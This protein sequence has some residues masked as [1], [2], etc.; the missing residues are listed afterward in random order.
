MR[1]SGATSRFR[2]ATAAVVWVALVAA[3]APS[4]AASPG[5][6]A[7]A[8]TPSAA[9]LLDSAQSDVERYCTAIADAA[10]DAHFAWQAKR[11][12]ELQTEIEERI[13]ALEAKRAEYEEW[14]QR[15]EESLAKAE[16]SVVA[17]YARM[18]PDAAAVQLARM[19]EE[20]A[21]AV[22][23]KLNSRLASAILNEMD[24]ERAARLTSSMSGDAMS[25]EDDQS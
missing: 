8:E 5:P 13:A 16:E 17:I 23:S 18:R 12:A 9:P 2:S 4:F 15:R 22:L 6:A 24:P 1:D 21:A 14:L 3:A 20:T 19:D 11:L 10:A 7:A 25:A